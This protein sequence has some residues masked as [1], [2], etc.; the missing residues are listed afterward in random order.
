MLIFSSKSISAKTWQGRE[1]GRGRER[2]EGEGEGERGERERE[3][4]EEREGRGERS[5][6]PHS[7]GSKRTHVFELLQRDGIVLVLIRFLQSPPYN[8]V[9]L[10][11]RS[12][13]V[14]TPT[15]VHVHIRTCSGGM[16]RP[17]IMCR[18]CLRSS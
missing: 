13:A 14:T 3:R 6:L 1:R 9:E 5:L 16:W 15:S 2:R 7:V 8:G 4:E 10:R 11:G 12:L 17:T 18:I